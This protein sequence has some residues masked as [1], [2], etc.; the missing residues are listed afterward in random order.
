MF[1]KIY[2]W[3]DNY[4]YHYKW[5]TLIALFFIV[6]IAVSVQQC[7]S[8]VDDD[9]TILYAGPVQFTGNQT[10][11][12]SSALK[13]VM[14]EDYNGDGV[15][16]AEIYSILLL[17]DK[18]VEDAKT[19][20]NADGEVLVYNQQTLNDNR[21]KFSTQIFAGETVICL[22]DPNW[23]SD[24]YKSGGFA[25]LKDILGYEP[26]YMIDECSVYLKD[27]PFA[28]YFTAMQA[29]PDDTILC[30]RTLS[31]VTSF[32]SQSSQQQNYENQ[33]DMFRCIM[34]FTLPEGALSDASTTD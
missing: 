15:L 3:F 24:V 14:S 6:F 23:Y 7:A 2:K 29:F 16:Q 9:V 1:K 27:T 18:Q 10:L 32:L 25:K 20:A 30:V 34:N 22:L 19:N 13:A 8:N 31:T 33:L 5:Q 21:T 26:D 17:T 12:M 11:E 4:W 28:Q